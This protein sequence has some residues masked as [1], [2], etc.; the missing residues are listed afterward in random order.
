MENKNQIQ[1]HGLLAAI[2]LVLMLSPIAYAR[3][4]GQCFKDDAGLGK[5][6]WFCNLEGKGDKAYAS[7]EACKNDCWAEEAVV[8]PQ[9]SS[10]QPAV[11]AAL[12]LNVGVLLLVF[13]VVNALR[14]EQFR[15]MLYDEAGHLVVTI[16]IVALLVAGLSDITNVSKGITCGFGAGACEE[17]PRSQE[18]LAG[19]TFCP[20]LKPQFNRQD[21]PLICPAGSVMDWAKRVNVNRVALLGEQMQRAI[22][23]N[24]KIGA[25][26]SVSAFCNLMGTG[27]TVAGCS[28]Y[29]VMRG[30][31]GQLV[32][33]SGIGLMEL[34]VQQ[35][36]LALAENYALALL[37]PLGLLLRCLHFTRKAGGT[38]IAIALALYVV[39]PPSILLSQALVDGFVGG[40]GTL[41]QLERG[42]PNL[43]FDYNALSAGMRGSAVM[44]CDPSEPDE[45][46][47]INKV[48]GLQASKDIDGNPAST[49]SDKIN[50][51]EAGSSVSERVIFLV[52]VRTLLMDAL[53]LTMLI[54]AVRVLGKLLGTEIEVS[55]IARL[56]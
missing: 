32:M 28:G 14:L 7:E 27:L 12:M 45:Q 23:F 9:T 15:A 40:Y 16:L 55:A 25:V 8:P 53:V 47:F 56:S 26:S 36:L 51:L 4:D 18:V 3:V 21:S 43:N 30:P 41:A 31:V 2:L 11:A 44:E 46:N 29:G 38:L 1:W 48:N 37:L 33:A 24:S 13:M 52:L 20:T 22:E 34:R 5:F 39:L 49:A 19:S 42:Y 50:T 54:M 35:I 6:A 17:H 10:W